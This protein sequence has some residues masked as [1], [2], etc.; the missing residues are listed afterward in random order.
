MPRYA[1]A[2]PFA[3]AAGAAV[4]FAAGPGGTVAGPCRGEGSRRGACPRRIWGGSVSWMPCVGESA[5]T[6]MAAAIEAQ[7]E[8]WQR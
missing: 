3:R 5:T 6:A 1:S 8:N 7:E 4:G 2:E